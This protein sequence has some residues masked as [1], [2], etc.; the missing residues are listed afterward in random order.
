[1]LLQGWRS[2]L[3]PYSSNFFIFPLHSP[4]RKNPSPTLWPLRAIPS[5]RAYNPS[6]LSWNPASIKLWPLGVTSSKDSVFCFLSL[7][8]FFSKA[9][10]VRLSSWRA[11][12]FWR[13]QQMSSGVTGVIG[14]VE[15]IVIMIDWVDRLI[16]EIIGERSVRSSYKRSTCS[17]CRWR[18]G[19]CS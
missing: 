8:W 12:L 7:V 4:L 6:H 10:K 18:R 13:W 3:F 16:R 1:M 17:G 11:I 14:D 15:N 5:S 9:S 19:R 2:H